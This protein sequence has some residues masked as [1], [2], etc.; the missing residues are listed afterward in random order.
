MRI[1]V[2]LHLLP[3]CLALQFPFG[4]PDLFK[5]KVYPP[6]FEPVISS[7]PRIAIIGAGAGGT[8]A[9]FWLSK[10]RERYGLDIEVDI[11]EQSSYI[12]GRRS[13]HPNYNLL[14]LNLV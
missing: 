10:A 1:I 4:I 14:S 6:A 2:L 13:F 12:G 3:V 7:T 5:A 11:Y 8:S 9:A